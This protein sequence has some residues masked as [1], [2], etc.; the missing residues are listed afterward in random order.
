M[1]TLND[2]A[3]FN[4][5]ATSSTTVSTTDAL[6]VTAG[7]L[8]WVQIKWEGA[9][10][11]TAQ[12]D[13]GASTPTF[14]SCNA[15]I[16][17]TNND[18]HG[19][20]FALIATSTGTVNPRMVLSAART[21]KYIRAYS[22]TPAG[23]KSFSATATAVNAAQGTGS[24]LSAGSASAGGAGV[25]FTAFDLYN[26]HTFTAGTGWTEPAEFNLDG[27]LACQYRLISGAGSV[28]GEESSTGFS[29][30]WIAQLAIFDEAASQ[31]QAARSMQQFRSRRT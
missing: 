17:H 29:D 1:A 16:D 24:P 23:G 12:V 8:V 18:L 6:N 11:V 30:A 25:A 20:T 26:S 2:T 22:V 19:Q 3:L 4:G 13:T 7:D 14:T 9:N 15:L 31:S 10:G 5:D 28:T 27:G 21:W